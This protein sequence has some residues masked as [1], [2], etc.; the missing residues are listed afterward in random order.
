MYLR[1]QISARRYLVPFRLISRSGNTRDSHSA[2]EFKWPG[3]GIGQ[4]LWISNSP[5][6]AFTCQ[7]SAAMRRIR[8]GPVSYS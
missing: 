2:L 1:S 5:F 3:R 7:I 4:D 8:I 6:S